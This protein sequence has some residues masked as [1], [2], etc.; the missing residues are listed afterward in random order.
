MKYLA[1]VL[2][3][4]GAIRTQA[5]STACDLNANGTVGVDDVQIATNQALGYSPCTADLNNDGI[6]NVADV[7]IVI[8]AALGRGCNASLQATGPQLPPVPATPQAVIIDTDVG[9]DID[10]AIALAIALR[11]QQ[12]GYI[13]IKAITTITGNGIDKG[14]A[15]VNTMLAYG[16]FTPAQIP[17]GAQQTNTGGC[18]AG[19]NYAS[20]TVIALGLAPDQPRSSFPTAVTVLRQTLAEAPD[21]SIMI[22]AIGPLTNIAQLIQSKADNTS[23]MTGAALFAAKVSALVTMGG[24]YPAHATDYN[25]YCDSGAAA[26]VFGNNGSVPVIGVGASFADDIYTGGL[27]A[28]Y[29]PPRSPM[30]VAISAFIARGAAF[31]T[32]PGNTGRPSWDPS[33]VFYSI[34][35][36]GSPPAGSYYTLSPNG[37]NTVTSPPERNSWSPSPASNHYYVTRGRPITDYASLWN[38]LLYQDFA[39]PVSPAK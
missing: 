32:G 1:L 29:L 21:G 31:S 7:Q 26:Y 15:F 19:D 25:Y 39:A 20:Q 10:D 22:V 8:N 24:D 30:A 5:S 11:A 4:I 23:S 28:S 37:T 16:G 2:T 13:R 35:G 14:P 36:S 6:C 18:G 34:A 27:Y 9:Y 38:S 3:L 17:I 12:L 33:T